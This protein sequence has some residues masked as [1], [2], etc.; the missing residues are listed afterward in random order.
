MVNLPELL[1]RFQEEIGQ[2]IQQEEA[3]QNATYGTDTGETELRAE[4]TRLQAE[5][6][7]E[8]EA[9]EQRFQEK[10]SAETAELDRRIDEEQRR[11]QSVVDSI[12]REAAQAT[13]EIE[14]QKESSQW[15]VESILDDTA[16]D[17]PV[18]EFEKFKSTLNKCREDQIAQ[19]NDV[20][21]AVKQEAEDRN[22]MGQTPAEPELNVDN[23]DAAQV[24][25]SESVGSIRADLKRL[26]SLWLPKLFEGFRSL[27]LLGALALVVFV[28]VVL[29]VSPSIFGIEGGAM[30]PA[31]L[32]IAFG[33]AVISS[34]IFC[35][36]LYTLGSMQQSDL[37]RELHETRSE[38]YWAHQYWLKFAKERLETQQKRFE[39]EQRKVQQ[40]RNT[41]LKRYNSAHTARLREIE[42]TK[43]TKLREEDHLHQSQ[44]SELQQARESRVAELQATHGQHVGQATT[45]WDEQITAIESQLSTHT[46]GRQRSLTEQWASLKSRWEQ[47]CRSLETDV[48]SLKDRNEQSF[49]PW[50]ELAGGEWRVPVE[51]PNS[52]RVGDLPIDLTDWPGAVSQD[53]RLSPRTTQFEIPFLAK[54]PEQTSLLFRSPQPEARQQAIQ[55]L[56]ALMLRLLTTIPPGKLRFTMIDPV[57]LGESFS[58]F[59]HLADFDELLV[60]NRIWTET[61]QIEARLADL[62]EH[63]ENVFQ[64]YL[65]NE[66]QT[67]EEYNVSAG[68][69]AEPYHILVIS[70][71]PAKFS[72]IAGR[73]LISIINSGPRCGVY[74]LMNMD[75]TKPLPNNFDLKDILPSMQSFSWKDDG[76]HPDQPETSAFRLQTDTPP[77]PDQFTEIVKTVGA[78]SKDARRV[79]VSFDRV[80]PEFKDVWQGDSRYEI[81]VPLGRAGATKLQTMKLGKGTSQ[82]M[83]VAGKTGSGKST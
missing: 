21:T 61:N 78:A 66:F 5:K 57:S 1:S 29:L 81:E 34:G 27:G 82:H 13:A 9:I 36:L 22:W 25:F 16:D 77:P 49:R 58:G 69:V 72:E 31:W 40:Q 41:A 65:R 59:M 73:R 51:I 47:A 14:Q 42:S 39:G 26:Q 2:R 17:S 45:N 23:I 30:Q 37:L 74:T 38:A 28:P 24:K 50:P 3:L 64:K 33:V 53:V 71:F 15:V 52:L 46:S 70:D 8:L 11:H 67:I 19:W 54:F 48:A 68:E 4:L 7:T 83:L 80:T 55:A 18:R 35:L 43:L 56:Q 44:A 6:S 62:T 63:M 76:F 12:E 60:T 32:G 10:L 20:D 75:P 79:E